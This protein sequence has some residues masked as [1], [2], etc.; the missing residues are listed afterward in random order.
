[1][2]TAEQSS[3]IITGSKP[4][5]NRTGLTF[6]LL[7]SYCLLAI[8]L[9][10]PTISH[11]TTH[12][13]GDG[14]D[15][16]A[17]AWN[18][19]WIKYALLNQGQTPFS[20]DFMFY[21]IDI[22]LAF[23]TLTVLNGFTA[24]PLT[25]NFGVVTASNLHMFFTFAIGGYGAFLLSY[26]LLSSSSPTLKTFTKPSPPD[27]SL[28]WFSAALAG[29]FY[30][31]AS[32]KLFYIALGQFNIGSS[33]WIPFAVLYLIKMHDQP[34]RLK[35]S[36]MAGLFF[37]FQAWSELT[38]ASFILVFIGLFWLYQGIVLLWQRTFAPLRLFVRNAIVLGVICT[39]GLVPILASMI[40]DMLT[41]GDF[42]VEG[43]GFADAF[44]ADLLGFI[45]P[46]MHHPLFGQLHTYSGLQNFDK[47]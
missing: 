16:P 39:L 9:T 31:F 7:I 35:N 43:G 42:F 33:H 17:I 1:M 41:E 12:L 4:P 2:N 13:P 45:I 19:W 37:T 25:L 21:P 34:H 3:P 24:L 15:D 28:I 23:Y 18:L 14:G 29:G 10:W 46:T 30:A 40:P 47:G 22:N 5:R 36:V 26:Y 8:I 44:S 6:F 20:S 11:V 32:S 38:Y 27:S